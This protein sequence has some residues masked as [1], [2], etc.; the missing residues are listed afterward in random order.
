MSKQ[1]FSPLL[2]ELAHCF[3]AFERLSGRHIR[4]LGLTPSQFDVI[5]ALGET[6]GMNCGDLGEHALITKG[7]LTGILDR[8]EQ[9]GLVLRKES[10]GDRRS[11]IVHLTSEGLSLFNQLSGLHLDY[12]HPAFNRLDDAFI[13]N[14]TVQLVHLRNT[15][16]QHAEQSP[17]H[18]APSR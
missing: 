4:S 13:E 7:T 11:V 12:L 6:D 10:P 8:L 9:K 14:M 15:L 16:Q 2:R 18:A 1:R 3:Q 5:T 17:I